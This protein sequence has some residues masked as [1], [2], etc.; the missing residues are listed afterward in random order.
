MRKDW[1]RH[2]NRATRFM[3]LLEGCSE[4]DLHWLANFDVIANKIL[5][6][7]LDEKSTCEASGAVPWPVLWV[8][9]RYSRK[10]IWCGKNEPSL[11]KISQELRQF[12]DKLKWLWHFRHMPSARPP[13]RIKTHCPFTAGVVDSGLQ[14]WLDDLQRQLVGALEHQVRQSKVQG[15]SNKNG[16][17]KLGLRQLAASEFTPAKTDKTGSYV[18]VR[19]V[20]F[21][22]LHEAVLRS[23]TYREYAENEASLNTFRKRYFGLVKIIAEEEGE[24]LAMEIRKTMRMPEN[25]LVAKLQVTVKTHKGQGEVSLRGI[26]ASTSYSFGGLGSWLA[27]RIDQFL[28]S[29]PHLLFSVFDVSKHL[30]AIRI[31]EGA[32]LVK[33]DIKDFFVSGNHEEL[34]RDSTDAVRALLQT[35][36]VQLFTEVVRLLLATQF[37]ESKQAGV[38]KQV[39][40]GSG[41]GLPQ[42]SA[43]MD[44]VFYWLAEHKH[45]PAGNEQV[46]SKVI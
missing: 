28:R 8:L 9:G 27:Y 20:A 24:E 13:V 30:E 35:D 45:L 14:W 6:Y 29:L 37:V 1:R 4:V 19:R 34:V 42:S 12:A 41:M 46:V 5:I 7:D 16:I 26:H 22:K 10:H 21:P 23:R 3:K 44:L 18:L 11:A 2:G 32:A 33:V 31:E 39:V 15:W 36:N 40:E 43:L 17:V 25:S 38:K